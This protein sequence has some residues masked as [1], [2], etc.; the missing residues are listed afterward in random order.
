MPGDARLSGL[1]CRPLHRVSWQTVLVEFDNIAG[2]MGPRDMTT[3]TATV[4]PTASHGQHRN[5]RREV[6]PL[7]STPVPLS[8][9]YFPEGA[10]SLGN[11]LHLGWL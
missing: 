4:T 7:T 3:I 10:L 6:L 5:G 2:L 11:R 9:F 8:L 1:C